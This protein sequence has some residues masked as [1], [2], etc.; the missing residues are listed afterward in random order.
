V[1]GTVVASVKDSALLGIKL[2][3]V[4]LVEGDAPSKVIVAGDATRQAGMDDFVTMIDA[5]EASMMF[6]GIDPPCDMA[7]TGFIDE[8]HVMEE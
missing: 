8:Y 1:E 6:R 7:I 5:K 3:L 4:R 2:L